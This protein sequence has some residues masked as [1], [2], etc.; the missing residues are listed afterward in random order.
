MVFR[1]W[2]GGSLK[3]IQGSP[4]IRFSP[5]CN[6]DCTSSNRKVF[7]QS[8]IAFIR[9]TGT[10]KAKIGYRALMDDTQK[11]LAW[12]SSHYCPAPSQSCE[13]SQPQ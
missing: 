8:D 11:N 12:P 5:I 1:Q 4:K 6:A 9:G 13:D 2:N 10:S 3:N 7:A